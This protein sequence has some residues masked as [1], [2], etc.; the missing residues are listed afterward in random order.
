MKTG[1]RVSAAKFATTPKV[2]VVAAGDTGISGTFEEYGG[3]LIL[4][5]RALTATIT[6][7]ALVLSG[8]PDPGERFTLTVLNRTSDTPSIVKLVFTVAGSAGFPGFFYGNTLD[9]QCP[10]PKPNAQTVWEFEYNHL[11][12]YFTMKSKTVQ[13][14][15]ASNR[16]YNLLDMLPIVGNQPQQSVR[17]LLSGFSIGNPK[18]QGPSDS[19]ESFFTRSNPTYSAEAGGSFAI[20]QSSLGGSLAQVLWTV[21][22]QKWT[23]PVS[24]G[25][26]L[27]TNSA[28]ALCARFATATNSAPR[29]LAG[30]STGELY[31]IQAVLNGDGNVT[32]TTFALGTSLG[33]VNHILQ[34]SP[35]VGGQ[36]FLISTSGGGV[37]Q[38][39][40]G[41]G[42]APVSLQAGNFTDMSRAYDGRV[43]ITGPSGVYFSN[44]GLAAL[45]SFAAVTNPSAGG[46]TPWAVSYHR[47]TNRWILYTSNGALSQ[48]FYST[49]NGTSWT[50]LTTAF[51]GAAA[52]KLQAIGNA[53]VF[54]LD[55]GGTTVCSSITFDGATFLSLS[56]RYSGP[57]GAFGFPTTTTGY[58]WHRGR[59]LK[60]GKEEQGNAIG[61]SLE[62]VGA[63][64]LF[65]F[66]K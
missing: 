38:F 41:F 14:F 60:T 10:D 17:A 47:A 26:A 24:G 5:C 23:Q 53:V 28:Y 25:G 11:T 33:A 35:E 29:L 37:Y 43:M 62:P 4:D 18:L 32:L 39:S 46:Y 3:N 6:S 9:E 22:G 1:S 56:G 36:Y 8:T 54:S 66:D 30:D 2:V 12:Y 31:R 16:T 34:F 40:T 15:G 21:D 19:S 20:F 7:Y 65:D 27:S 49:N 48:T 57:G 64:G 13:M 55:V 52:M 59:I 63:M 44:N 58:C 50:S 61:L 51:P 45:P 42:A